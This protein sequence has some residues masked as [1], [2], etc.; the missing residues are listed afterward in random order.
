MIIRVVVVED[1]MLVRMG[2]TVCLTNPDSKH[3]IQVLGSF[4][5]GEE[6]LEFFK[7]QSADVL[8]TDVRLSG[9]TGLDLIRA[10]PEESRPKAIIVISY[11]NDFNYAREALSLGVDRYLLK[12]EIDENEL[13]ILVEDIMAQKV[14]TQEHDEID[15]PR[16]NW[17]LK[18]TGLFRLGIIMLFDQLEDLDS[19]PLP[20]ED[21][22]GVIPASRKSDSSTSPLKSINNHLFSQM[23]QGQLDKQ[24]MGAFFYK[25]QTPCILFDLEEQEATIQSVFDELSHLIENYFNKSSC[26]F[27]SEPFRH[28]HEIDIIFAQIHVY[29]LQQH[30]TPAQVYEINKN[31]KPIPPAALRI[32]QYIDEHYHEAL[33]L[34]TLA[35]FC[36]MNPSYF[37]QYFKKTF[38]VSFVSYLNHLR[39]NKAKDLLLTTN[40][41]SEE[42]AQQI[43]LTNSNY[44]FRLFKKITSYT[45]SEF[46]KKHNRA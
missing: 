38:G 17:L 8:I 37:C 44:Y 14:I 15:A 33:S 20:A 40:L 9:M 27:L 21:K 31:T 10:L 35:G 3:E 30:Y 34:N 41:S 42:I 18:K 36:H 11:Y 46:L 5:S 19:S 32:K 4:A 23:L 26:L 25:S 28:A 43:G 7:H 24:N 29:T 12:S 2:M 1:E 22:Q 39:I 16:K 6:A 45:T 13:Y